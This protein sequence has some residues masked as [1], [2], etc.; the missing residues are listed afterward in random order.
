MAT[1][2][3]TDHRRNRKNFHSNTSQAI[4]LFKKYCMEKRM[5]YTPERELIIRE[6]YQ[7]D[8]HFDVD[9]LFLRLRARHPHSR[10]AKTSIYRSVP[11]L[12]DAGLLRESI[13]EAGRVVYERTIGRFDHDHF[14]CVKCGKILEFYS[15]ELDTAQKKICEQENFKILWRTNVVNGYCCECSNS[16]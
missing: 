15:P 3:L 12:L 8:G 14:R 4:R 6:V 9:R 7:A 16:L 1:V 13:A 2:Q 5:R 11:Y 10:I